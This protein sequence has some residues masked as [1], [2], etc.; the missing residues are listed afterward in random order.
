IVKGFRFAFIW[1]LECLWRQLLSLWVTDVQLT[2][3]WDGVTFL[4]TVLRSYK[5]GKK[6]SGDVHFVHFFWRMCSAKFGFEPITEEIPVQTV[7]MC[8]S[9]SID[10]YYIRAPRRK[11]FVPDVHENLIFFRARSRL[12][13]PIKGNCTREETMNSKG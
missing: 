5:G 3:R 1:M 12:G 6:A 4:Y 13:S 11:Q 10:S 9:P 2:C 8:T 7:K